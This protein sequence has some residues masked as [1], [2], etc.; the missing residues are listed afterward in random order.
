MR[1]AAKIQKNY[2]SLVV[3]E[4]KC[5]PYV[6]CDIVQII[7]VYV[8]VSNDCLL[9]LKSFPFFHVH[10]KFRLKLNEC[11]DCLFSWK[12]VVRMPSKACLCAAAYVSLDFSLRIS[13]SWLRTV[14]I[15][16][17]KHFS[18][19]SAIVAWRSAAS[20]A[21]D[22]IRAS[23]IVRSLGISLTS[24][25]PMIEKSPWTI[26]WLQQHMFHAGRKW[27]KGIFKNFLWE[28]NQ[29]LFRFF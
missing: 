17:S 9:F 16:H 6:L 24:C 4:N 13:F 3:V 28:S 18:H 27:R 22:R 29:N 15:W 1:I 20:E 26:S 2:V 25:P 5:F 7:C 14:K 23:K 11:V 19:V 21:K 10:T 8:L 12:A